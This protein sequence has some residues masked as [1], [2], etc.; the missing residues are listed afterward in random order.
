MKKLK[1]MLSMLMVAA[2]CVLLPNSNLLTASAAE[3]V[4]Y[5]VK[6]LANDG[7]WR[8]M[9][10]SSWTEGGYHRELYYLYEAIKDGDSIV[11]DGANPGFVLEVPVRLKNVTLLHGAAAVVTAS[12]IDE[13]YILRDSV[14][15]INGNV[16]TAYVYDNG[17]CTFNN[18]VGTLTILN[19]SFLVNDTLLHGTVTVN[20]TV[21]HLIGKDNIQLHYEHYN[22]AAGKLVITNGDVKTDAAYYS[23]TPSGTSSTQ[24]TTTQSTP[25]ST[26]SGDEYDDVPKTGDSS[27]IFWLLGIS[28]L[29]FAGS[30]LLKAKKA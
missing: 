20:G 10:G 23:N 14:G 24:T 5:C 16:T 19:D 8:Y 4:T 15:A 11:I 25:S 3:P 17:T 26:D 9:E 1:K 29:C 30:S 28:A 18:N 21:D 6:Y 13:C 12:S 27:L 7:Q 22:F 2:I